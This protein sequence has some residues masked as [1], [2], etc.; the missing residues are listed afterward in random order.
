[1]LYIIVL[2]TVQWVQVGSVHPLR[3]ATMSQTNMLIRSEFREDNITRPIGGGGGEKKSTGET[4][5]WYEK[6]TTY[7]E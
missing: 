1:V 6:E 5:I 7:V 4:G 2:R 3:I